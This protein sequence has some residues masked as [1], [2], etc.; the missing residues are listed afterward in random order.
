M[1]GKPEEKRADSPEF[2]I[3]L[4]DDED[5]GLYL[6]VK[7]MLEEQEKSARRSDSAPTSAS[8][9]P[10]AAEEPKPQEREVVPPVLSIVSET[11][12]TALDVTYKQKAPQPVVHEVEQHEALPEASIALPPQILMEQHPASGLPIIDATQI[13]LLD[14]DSEDE[15]VVA[16]NFRI[17]PQGVSAALWSFGQT[18]FETTV[19]LLGEIKDAF[20][21]DD[22][23]DSE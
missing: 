7:R 9:L 19:G 2:S 17:V 11:S 4:I 13:P 12:Q 8:L 15:E 5:D 22:E 14:S 23:S 21:S 10:V 3:S 6:E 16:D 1:S 18:F 20:L